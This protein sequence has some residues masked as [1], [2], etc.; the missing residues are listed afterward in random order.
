MYT[1]FPYFLTKNL[2]ELPILLIQPLIME[3]V[4]YWGVGYNPSESSFWR[5]YLA[6]M[7]VA[8]TAAG[9]GFMIS[10]ACEKMEQAT[11]ISSLITLPS[12][13]F[14][15]LFVNTSTVFAALSWIQWLSPIRYGFEMLCIAEFKPRGLEYLYQDYLGFGNKPGY[16]VCAILLTLVALLS[17]ILS[18]LVL[19][20]N[21]KK[22]Q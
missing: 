5:F 9:F 19:K 18:V 20:L 12:I 17:R 21:I 4:V 1:L 16:W 11:A 15:G 6:L 8:Q 14:G 2:I 13:L 10:C 7:L 22:F 3:L